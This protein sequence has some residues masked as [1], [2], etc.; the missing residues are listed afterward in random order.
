VTPDDY[1]QGMD[2]TTKVSKAVDS[3]LERVNSIHRSLRWLPKSNTRK[4]GTLEEKILNQILSGKFHPP[5]PTRNS[6][7]VLTEHRNRLIVSSSTFL[8]EDHDALTQLCHATQ[9]AVAEESAISTEPT[10]FVSND[11]IDMLGIASET[12]G[13]EPLFATD[14]IAPTGFV[15]LERPLVVHVGAEHYVSDRPEGETIGIRAFSWRQGTMESADGKVTT[16]AGIWIYVY[17]D[18]GCLRYISDLDDI[19]SLIPDS[20]LVL[21]DNTGWSF[22]A[23][24]RPA[25]VGERNHVTE[26]GIIVAA[27]DTVLLRKFILSLFRFMWQELLVRERPTASELPRSI[28]RGATRTLGLEEPITILKLRRTRTSSGATTGDG[29]R[30][31]H[32]ILVR[33]H[34]RNQYYPSLG[35]VDSPESHRL[36]WIE[37]HVKG[38]EDADFKVKPKATAVVR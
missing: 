13:S 32:R 9:S 26:D 3:H 18:F 17:T 33:G 27:P 31:D 38:P 34:W 7:G 2:L 4:S 29:S 15:Y 25:E 1:N 14:L 28:R 37:P 5:E 36:I 24:W 22:G 30:L 11:I 19:D 20:V 6:L 8:T 21:S 10:T 12:V 35:H 16:D 23:H